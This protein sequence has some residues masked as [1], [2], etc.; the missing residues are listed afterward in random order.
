MKESFICGRS[1]ND[2]DMYTGALSEFPI[3]GGLVGP[4]ITCLISDQFKRLKQGDSFWY[5]TDKQPQAFTLG[6]C[7]GF[8]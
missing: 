5:E 4:T 2:I 7:I 6:K 3:E 8:Q 1:V